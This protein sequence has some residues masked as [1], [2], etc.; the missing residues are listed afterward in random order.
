MKMYE[1]DFV[2][3]DVVEFKIDGRVFKYRPVTAGQENDWLNEYMI[4]TEDGVKQDLTKLNKFKVLNI[5]EV[6]YSSE[7]IQTILKLQAPKDWK[8][9]SKDQK[10]ELLG[11]LNPNLFSEIVTEIK[12]IDSPIKKKI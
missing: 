9:L 7:L 2:S 6:P 3:E 10:W 8:D 5:V 12:K 11:K 1:T 4:F